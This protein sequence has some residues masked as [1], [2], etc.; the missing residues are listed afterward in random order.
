MKTPIMAIYTGKIITIAAGL[1][2]A[3]TRLCSIEFMKIEASQNSSIAG[4]FEAVA[5][6]GT[7]AI[8]GETILGY[9]TATND[10]I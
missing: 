5:I 4:I 2:S 1:I 9:F 10:E 8:A 6:V 3:G 7:A